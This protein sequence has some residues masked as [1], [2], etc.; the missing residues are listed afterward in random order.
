MIPNLSVIFYLAVFG[1]I[2]AVLTLLGGAAWLIWF[3]INHVQI[4]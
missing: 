3:A 4:I 1:A 2:C